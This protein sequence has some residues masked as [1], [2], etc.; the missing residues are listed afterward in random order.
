MIIYVCACG[1]TLA[2]TENTEQSRG[3]K[4]EWKAKHGAPL[5]ERALVRKGKVA[6]RGRAG[7]HGYVRRVTRKKS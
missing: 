1:D 4:R 3:V 7:I 5:I 2:V 6:D